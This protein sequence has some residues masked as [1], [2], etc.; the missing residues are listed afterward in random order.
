MYEQL[1]L[2]VRKDI[3]REISVILAS[4]EKSSELSH[5]GSTLIDSLKMSMQT[6]EKIWAFLDQNPQTHLDLNLQVLVFSLIWLNYIEYKGQGSLGPGIAHVIKAYQDDEKI[7]YQIGE[8]VAKS[9]S[10]NA[11]LGALQQNMP[12]LKSKFQI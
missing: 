6:G 4:Y 7:R 11:F 2:Q 8:I 10:F 1:S 5:F 3:N 12:G 9:E